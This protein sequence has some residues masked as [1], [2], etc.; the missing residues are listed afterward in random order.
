VQLG[1]LEKEARAENLSCNEMRIA[2]IILHL[3]SRRNAA[4][5]QYMRATRE[6]ENPREEAEMRKTTTTHWEVLWRT[7]TGGGKKEARK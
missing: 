7:T 1:G 4:T 3:T 5:F 6:G 2:A